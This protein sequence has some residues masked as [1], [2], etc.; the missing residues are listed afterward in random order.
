MRVYVRASH[1]HTHTQ[2][3]TLGFHKHHNSRAAKKYVV[4]TCGAA[5]SVLQNKSAEQRPVQ[6]GADC[7]ACV[8]QLELSLEHHPHKLQL[9]QMTKYRKIPRA[10]R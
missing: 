9:T 2:A 10:R 1:R 7:S 3:A 5:V 4:I 8:N 6:I